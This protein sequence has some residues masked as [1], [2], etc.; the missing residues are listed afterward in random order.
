[1]VR[2]TADFGIT[3]PID[4]VDV[5]VDRDNLLFIDPSAIRVAARNGDVYGKS[6]DASLTAFFNEVLRQLRSP[7]AADHLKGE[8]NLQNFGE[9]SATRL[10]LSRK[11]TDGHG[12]AEKLGTRMWEELLKNPLCQLAVAT[13]KFVEDIPLFVEG[14]DRDITSDLT[15]RIILE[16]LES[17]TAD[18]VIKHPELKARRPMGTLRVKYWDHAHGKWDHKTMTLPVADGKPLLLVPRS[19]V[20]YKIQMTY[21]QYYQVPL[22]DYIQSEDLVSVARGKKL[23][24]RPR[25]TKKHLKTTPALSRSRETN[26][27]QTARIFKKDGTDVLGDYRTKQQSSFAPLTDAQLDHYIERKP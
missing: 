11:G 17:F 21:G 4:F 6:A 10:G 14:I 2:I 18:M 25:F 1:M 22:L 13:L 20:N 15:A 24:L 8:A 16:T 7:V 3:G 19:F 12:A 27:K 26:C 23:V 5:H 9:I